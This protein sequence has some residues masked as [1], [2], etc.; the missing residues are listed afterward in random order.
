MLETLLRP[1]D[2][3][4]RCGVILKDTTVV[5]I[6]NVASDKTTSYKMCPK[7]LLPIIDDV[8]ATW[9][10]H[11]DSDPNLS[12]EDRVGFLMWPKLAHYIV[13]RR[14]GKVVVEKYRVEDGFVLICD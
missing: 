5:E 14:A 3:E 10:T 7:E 2:T 11:P 9:H 8:V 12:E 13:G 4:E 6:T 1:H